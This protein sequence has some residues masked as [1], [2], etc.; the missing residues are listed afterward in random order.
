LSED[1]APRKHERSRVTPNKLSRLYIIAY[2]HKLL[3][4]IVLKQE[5][6]RKR[7]EKLGGAV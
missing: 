5:T 7:D 1:V 4:I 2:R 3:G 6:I